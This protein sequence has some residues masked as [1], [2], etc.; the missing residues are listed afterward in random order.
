MAFF[1]CIYFCQNSTMLFYL[2]SRNYRRM[3]ERQK[4]AAI[5]ER[6]ENRQYFY[7]LLIKL[8]GVC[9]TRGIRLIIEN[10]WTHPQYLQQNF[11]APP[12]LIDKDRSARGDYFR[13]PTAYWFVNCEPLLGNF[14]EQRDK[15]VCIVY[16]AKPAPRGGLCSEERSMISPDYARNFIR[17]F[18]LGKPQPEI[19]PTLFNF[20]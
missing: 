15:E 8:Y 17:D 20:E 3:N 7:S 14:T 4:I 2:S 1:P 10:P 13:K 18:I 5:L 6:S 16:N 9:L 12:S 19:C 11:V